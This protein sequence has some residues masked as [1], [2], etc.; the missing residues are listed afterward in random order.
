MT[1]T[2]LE[3][4]RAK[5]EVYRRTAQTI[6]DKASAESR[7]LTT[8][9]QTDVNALIGKAENAI[10][11]AELAQR[12]AT[13]LTV[14]DGTRV[15]VGDDNRTREPW[16]TA[17]DET[18]AFGAFLQ[19]VAR[20][21]SPGGVVDPR[22]L[23]SRAASGLNEGLGGS[24]GFLVD[25][26]FSS[27]ILRR[28]YDLG[29]LAK[30]C[31]R[32]P[33]GANSNGIR[34]PTVDETSRATGSR[35][36]G[37][38][39]FRAA[40]GE[41]V[42]QSKP[43]FGRLEME[44]EKLM[45]LGYTTDEL[46]QDATALGAVMS[47]SFSEE[48][49]FVVDDEIFRGTGAG[50]CLGV[51]NSPAL[52]TVTKEQS[53]SAD[54]IVYANIRRMW[55]RCWGRSRRNAVWLI[56]QDCEDQLYSL[57]QM[58][59]TGGAPVFLPGGGVSQAPYASLYGRP[60]VP[61]EQASALGDL[62]DIVLADFGEYLLID[63]PPQAAQSLHVKFETDEMVFRFTYRISGQPTWK[64]ALTPYK[65]ANTLSPFVALEAR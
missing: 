51:L 63:K 39:V 61:I 41:T 2:Y 23:Q 48:I 10:K 25:H 11:S 18:R 19:S 29:E 45:G 21:C 31:R 3:S 50:Q 35:L 7:A 44:L 13:P 27:V 43:K 14:P 47:Q 54:T 52:A 33:I 40:E 53:Q 55:S 22:L 60:V 17:G 28:A 24:G 56:N 38:R 4:I 37:V 12:V 8:Q 57:S 58:V 1:S 30:R 59:G 32:I 62:G 46:L 6:L 9:E 15:Q 20:A 42:T 34:I 36:G 26:Q 5:S 64:T 65:G 16:Q 49:S